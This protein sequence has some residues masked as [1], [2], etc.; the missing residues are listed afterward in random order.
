MQSPPNNLALTL[1]FVLYAGVTGL[2]FVVLPTMFDHFYLIPWRYWWVFLFITP[3]LAG[4]LL[5]WQVHNGKCSKLG[6][7]VFVL[8]VFMLGLFYRLFVY[9]IGM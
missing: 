5:C 4:C 9:Y 3:P 6:A 2:L 8:A 1:W 7:L